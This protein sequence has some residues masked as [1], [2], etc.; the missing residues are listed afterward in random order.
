MLGIPILADSLPDNFPFIGVIIA[1]FLYWRGG[2][3]QRLFVVSETGVRRLRSTVRR[4]RSIVFYLGLVVIVLALQ[5]PLDT[6]SDS[7]FWAHMTQ[8]MLLIGVAAPFFM[9]AAPWMRLWSGLPLGF[10][11]PVAKGV[12]VSGWAAPLRAVG[13]FFTRPVVTWAA[14][15]SDMIGWHLPYLYHLTLQ[16]QIVHDIEHMSFLIFGILFWAQLFDSPPFHSRMD[17]PRRF[18]FLASSMFPP[19]MLALIFVLS[20]TV[21]YPFYSVA[22]YRASGISEMADQQL[23]GAIMWMPGE[24]PFAVAAFLVIYK[25]V[26]ASQEETRVRRRG[27]R[28]SH[29]DAVGLD[30]MTGGNA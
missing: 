30:Q 16:I 23:A 28:G 2:R 3:H 25:W 15:L 6:W 4:W 26:E 13:R 22:A 24:I 12:L 7:L 11:R 19:W 21:L 17:W 20:G 18:V 8:H 1:A 9:A 10:R 14:F 29:G 5:P 27:K